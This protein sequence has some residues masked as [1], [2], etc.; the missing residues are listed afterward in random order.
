MVKV[1]AH[2]GAGTGPLENTLTGFRT[3]IGWEVDCIECDVRSSQEGTPVL[4]HDFTLERVSTEEGLVAEKS[5]KALQALEI[6]DGEKIPTLTEFLDLVALHKDARINLDVKVVDIEDQIW[7]M[8]QDYDVAHRTIISSFIQPVLTRF[9][10]INEELATALIYEYDLQNPVEVARKLG[11][12]AINPQLHFVDEQLVQFCHQGELEINPWVI[13]EPEE[14][15]RFIDW[16]VD[17]II[18]DCSPR[19]LQILNRGS[20]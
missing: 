9:R 4:L 10:N 8:I 18:T 2:R 14:M 5:V 7:E 11:C 6:G 20:A 12:T 16:G 13:N 19:L 17:G 15:R 1:I 3:A